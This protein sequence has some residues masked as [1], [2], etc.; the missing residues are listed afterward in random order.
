[1]R[2]LVLGRANRSNTTDALVLLSVSLFSSNLS[3]NL[4]SS[5]MNRWHDCNN[6]MLLWER[7]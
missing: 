1:M 5:G 6:V 3:L 2:F 4:R 7:K